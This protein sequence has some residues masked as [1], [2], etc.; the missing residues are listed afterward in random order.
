MEFACDVAKGC[1][2][3]SDDVSYEFLSAMAPAATV[4][5]SGDSESHAHP[6]PSI[7]AASALTGHV[8][9]DDDELLTPLIY[10][11]EVSRS[12]R[13]GKI[14]HVEAAGAGLDGDR[15]DGD[16]GATIHYA[17]LGA[18]D[19][20]AKRGRRRLAGAY[21]VAGMIYGLVNVRTDGERVLCATLNE[22]KRTWDC[23]DFASRF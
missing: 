4:I 12:V 10:S 11:T 18:G 3:G 21:V 7:V 19:L 8:R 9:V 6:R 13:M 2:H 20:R 15:L 22:K 17:E 14:T 23:Q 1:H 16:A 5:S